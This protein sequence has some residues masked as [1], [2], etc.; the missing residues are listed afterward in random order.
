MKMGGAY[1]AKS[2][3]SRVPL[4]RELSDAIY[5]PACLSGVSAATQTFLLMHCSYVAIDTQLAHHYIQYV[6]CV[7]CP[8]VQEERISSKYHAATPK[9]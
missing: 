7:F 1:N 5:F 9:H 6:I 3:L 8:Q 2:Q 4:A